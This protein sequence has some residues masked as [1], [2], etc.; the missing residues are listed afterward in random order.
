MKIVL[1]HGVLGF[2]MLGSLGYFN[3]IA[4]HLE[5]TFPELRGNVIAPMVNPVGSVEDRAPQLA[6]H[7]ARFAGNE[8]VHV[9]AHSMGGLDARSAITNNLFGVAERIATLVCIGT[10][11]HGSAVADRIASG[12]LPLFDQVRVPFVLHIDQRALHDLTTAVAL[13]RDAQMV[14]NRAVRYLYVAGDMMAPDARP[15]LAF[16][17]IETVFGLGRPNDGVVTVDSATRGGTRPLFAT[18]PVDHAQ[19][20]G[21]NLDL[22]VPAGLPLSDTSHFARYEALVRAVAG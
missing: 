7:I 18:W 15:S 12:T 16:R 14:D 2:G 10:P 11:H 22:L 8:R 6:M 5:R 17:T 20:V 9:F 19:E 21:W 13:Q 3:G 1:A 4:A